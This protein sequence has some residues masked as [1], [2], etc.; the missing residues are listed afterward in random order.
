M[1]DI[2]PDIKDAV[3]AIEM[4]KIKG[5]VE[6]RNMSF[7]YQPEKLILKD[8]NFKVN[9]GETIALVDLLEQVK[10]NCKFN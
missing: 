1:M 5:T 4:P 6:F 10:Y 8:V 2:K 9:A 3:D 7:Y